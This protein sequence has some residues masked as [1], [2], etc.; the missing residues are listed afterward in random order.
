MMCAFFC[1][2]VV[3]YM[4][5]LDAAF[6]FAL[7]VVGMFLFIL[8]FLY[9]SQRKARH[10]TELRKLFSDL[11]AETVICDTPEEVKETL[12]QFLA[13]NKALL[14]KAFPRKILTREIVKTKDSISGK[15]AANLCTLFEELSLDKDTF[16]HFGSSQWHRKASAIQRLAEM[17]QTKYLLK[18]YRETNNQN[19]LV[20]T[21]A[22]I[23]VVKLTGF[24]GLRFLNIVSHPVSQWQ[25]LS[26]INQLQE[27]E[28]EEDKIKAWLLSKN[29]TVVE[30]ALRLVE[31]YKCFGLHNEAATC[32]QHSSAVVRTQALHALKEI[33][34]D[35]TA[36]F[37]LQAFPTVTKAEQITILEMLADTATGR[38]V[39]T[40]LTSLLKNDDK[41]IR[42]RA[43]QAIQKI[44]PAW[45][46]VVIRQIQENPQ[47]THILP[48][49]QKEAV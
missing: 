3:P 36:T 19:S 13:A 21:E 22:Q 47:F 39:L 35:T 7:V 30:F 1:K 41:A 24:K 4:W 45:S 42:L 37:L 29:E 34:D 15:S 5:V 12:Q 20:R 16:A 14:D 46:S 33:G 28:A 10:K 27:G 11:I 40:F 6:C 9:R 44:S 2:T 49:L 26:L 18:I 48:V 38:N 31:I 17:Q 8:C 23:A 43:V 32:L 25:Q